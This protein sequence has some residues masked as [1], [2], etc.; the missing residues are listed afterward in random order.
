MAVDLVLFCQEARVRRA[1]RG[2]RTSARLLSQRAGAV[3]PVMVTLTYAR[4]DGWVPGHL[5]EYVKRVR[6]WA[7]RQALRVWGYVWAAELQQRGAVHYHVLFWLPRRVTLPKSD[8][9][10]WWTHGSTR[11]ERARNGPSYISKYAS[12]LESKG[13]EFPRGLRLHGA[14]GLDNRAIVERRWW[15][16]PKWVRDVTE[17][18]SE[19]RRASG[20]GYVSV[21]TGEVFLSGWR[22]VGRGGEGSGA[23]VRLVNVGSEAC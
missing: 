9:R 21:L 6:E 1:A 14:G 17:P 4:S 7:R 18:G 8:K 16:M 5:T 15:L 19:L 10:G 12:K 3:R 11:T 23:W 22:Y 20:G 13:G 2:I